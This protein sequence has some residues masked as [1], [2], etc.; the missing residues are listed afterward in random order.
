MHLDNS[1]QLYLR[2]DN[3]DAYKSNGGTN[4]DVFGS[5]RLELVDLDELLPMGVLPLYAPLGPLR[6]SLAEEGAGGEDA[7]GAGRRAERLRSFTG[8]AAAEP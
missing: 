7:A 2:F 6:L 5:P 4:K 3:K 1:C 8:A